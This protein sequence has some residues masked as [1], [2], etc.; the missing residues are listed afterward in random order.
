M[1]PKKNRY[2]TCIRCGRRWNVSVRA[3]E[4]GAYICPHCRGKERRRDGA[5]KDSSAH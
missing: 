5:Q 1:T 3:P 2:E 4:R